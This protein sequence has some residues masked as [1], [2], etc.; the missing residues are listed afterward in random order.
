MMKLRPEIK[1]ALIATYLLHGSGAK[2]AILSSWFY[3]SYIANGLSEQSEGLQ[4]L[5][6]SYDGYDLVNNL[7]FAELN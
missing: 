7:N 2:E 4:R 1:D 6:N 3:G 5:R